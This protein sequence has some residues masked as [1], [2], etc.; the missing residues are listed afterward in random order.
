MEIVRVRPVIKCI[1]LKDKDVQ[2]DFSTAPAELAL[3]NVENMPKSLYKAEES[4][5]EYERK[6]VWKITVLEIIK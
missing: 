5:N 6:V 3:V 4:I 1:P 2:I